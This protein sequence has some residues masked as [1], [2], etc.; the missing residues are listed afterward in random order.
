[1][2][3]F[4]QIVILILLIG[5]FAHGLWAADITSLI[6]EGVQDLKIKKGSASL[7]ALTD[8][9]Y[10][11]V[12]GKTTEGYVD[13]IQE[14]TGCSIGKGNL[15]FYHRPVTYPLKIV[16][17]KKDMGDAVVI[18]YNGEKSEKINLRMDSKEAI[19]PDGWKQIQNKLGPDTFSIVSITDAWAKGAPYDFLRCCEFHNHLCPGVSSGY[20]IGRFILDKYPLNQGESYAWFACPY[21][22]KDDAIQILLDLTPGKRNL[23]VKGL[24]KDQEM[25]VLGDKAAGNI[26]GILV[27]WNNKANN[28]KA[29]A[30]RYDWGK[31]QEVSGVAGKDFAPKGGITNPVFWTSR[32]KCNVGLM[33]Y[34][35]KPAEFVKVVKK[36]E[37]TAQ[38]YTK[39]TIAGTNPYEVIDLSK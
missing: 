5:C 22:C 2:K 6:K 10:V 13:M 37:I 30:F 8:A 31:A 12:N 28:G 21:W 33:P 4:I 36:V 34:L 19:K 7:L 3:R 26:A 27:I 15:L 18:T 14:A 1:M 16:L 35:E 20:Q 11:K 39:M 25:A 9:T 23:F 24:T 38:M 29:V 32:L 17:F